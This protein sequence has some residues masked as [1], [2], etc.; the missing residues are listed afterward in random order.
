MLTS[1]DLEKISTFI[2]DSEHRLENRIVNI[3]DQRLA[4]QTDQILEYVNAFN[5]SHEEWLR[6]RDVR[7]VRLEENV[8][9]Q[10]K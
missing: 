1:Q 2:K 4:I 8:F 7:I 3:F 5:K 10:L 9:G 6:N